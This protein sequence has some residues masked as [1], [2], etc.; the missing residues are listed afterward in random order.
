M[1]ER[2]RRIVPFDEIPD[3]RGGILDRMHPFHTGPAHRR[4]NRV[5]NDDEYRHAI[6]IRVV[7]RHRRVLQSNR[8]MG[9]HTERFTFDFRIAVRHSDRGLLVTAS[10]ELG[11]L[12]ASIVDDGFVQR[13]KAGPRVGADV[14][15]VERAKYIY[16]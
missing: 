15:D 11:L 2:Y 9:K 10:D 16:H 4:I 5:P 14:L 1:L 8:A 12:V 7:D 3:D 6:A 13:A